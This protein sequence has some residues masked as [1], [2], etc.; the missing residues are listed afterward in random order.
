MKRYF[1]LSDSQFENIVVAIGQRLFGVGLMGFTSGK[2]GGRDAKFIGTAQDYPSKNS[3]WN[4]CTIIQAKHTARI[5]ASYSDADVYKSGRATGLICD[6]IPKIKALFEAGEAQNYFLISNRKLSAITQRKITKF[7]SDETGMPIQN[8]AIAGT[9]QLDGWLAFYPEAQSSISINPLEAPLIVDPDD[10][11]NAIEGFREA[12]DN[13]LAEEDGSRPT[14]RTPLVEKNRLN[15]MTVEFEATLRG[16]YIKH[17]QSIRK[18]LSDPI[19]EEYRASYQ[20]AVEEFNLKIVAKREEYETFDAIFD[21]LLYQLFD[22][23]G[24]LGSN[25]GL[26]RAMLYYMYYNCDIGRDSDDQT[27]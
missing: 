19:N 24:I 11:A 25:K 27:I 15:N 8:I 2:D 4:G 17:T 21:Y 5:N 22:R 3:L 26:T 20:E 14:P 6:E 7:I 9:Q 23:S 18:F 1:D 13:D 10:L 16:Y 12:L